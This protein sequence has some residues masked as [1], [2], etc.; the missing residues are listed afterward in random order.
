MDETAE[1]HHLI[2]RTFKG[3]ETITLHKICHR[4]I[5][6][7]FSERELLKEFH[8]I[9]K[10]LTNEGIQNFVKWVSNKAPDFCV[11]GKDSVK[12]KGKRRR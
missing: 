6:V 9:D 4:Q 3:K 11:S 5:H 10:L 2:P 1:E 7:L 8:T 12:R